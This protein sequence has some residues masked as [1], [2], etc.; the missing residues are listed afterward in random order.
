MI[1][2]IDPYRT[3]ALVDGPAGR[4]AVIDHGGHGPDVLLLHGANRTALD[5]QALL[6]H[7]PG[8]R[9]VAMDL[10]G[11]G[12]S[13]APADGDYGWASHLA[14]VDAVI[15]ALGLREP[16]LIGH[17]LGGM[18]AVRHAAT[19]PGCPGIVDLDGFGS[20]VPSLYP[21]LAPSEVAARRAEQLALY[22]ALPA[23]SADAGELLARARAS[24]KRLGWA[25]D[26]EEAGVLRSL[27]PATGG[28]VAVRPAPSTLPAL[29]APIDGWDMFAEVRSLR[30]PVL[31]VQGGRTPELGHLPVRVRELTE[32]LIAGI[33]REL[34]A[35]RAEAGHVRAVSLDRAA[36][37][38]HLDEPAVVAALVREAVLGDARH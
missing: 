12:R 2:P 4:I 21:G 10:R 8:L 37:M 6:P 35:L 18:I 5:W 29:M 23:V 13:Q 26:V 25:P 19:H 34:A 20:G 36:H 3:T 16:W 15:Q 24:A 27:A 22:A 28:G 38:L 30:C 17:S 33:G 7:L 1:D 32:A 11:H 9:L 14:D 31:L